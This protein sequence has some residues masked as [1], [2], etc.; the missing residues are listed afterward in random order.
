MNMIQQPDRPVTWEATFVGGRVLSS[1]QTTWSEFSEVRRDG[2]VSLSFSREPIEKLLLW[3]P[4][5][6]GV[7]I[8]FIPQEPTSLFALTRLATYGSTPLW[9]YSLF[10]FYEG[11]YRKM[12]R[13]T[14]Y[15]ID[16]LLEPRDT[17]L[18]L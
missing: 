18:L 10:G 14:A 16:H 5:T 9:R 6:F 12:L 7:P 1:R 8:P 17:P 15:G 4:T 2:S 11:N 3:V 13:V